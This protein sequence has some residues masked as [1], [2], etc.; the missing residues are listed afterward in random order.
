MK[1]RTTTRQLNQAIS[2]HLL[3]ITK[4]EHIHKASG[5]VDHLNKDEFWESL[6]YLNES[7]V[8]ADCI[9]WHYEM[10]SKADGEIVFESGR[11]NPYTDYTIVTHMCVN[12]GVSVED[13]NEMLI[14]EESE[15]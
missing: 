13:V 3:K 2:N 14:M 12:D 7:G 11:L 15:D 5:K 1:R 4:A 6:Q 9:D 8:F 10:D